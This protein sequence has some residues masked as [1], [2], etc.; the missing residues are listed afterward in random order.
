[1][2]SM[3]IIETSRSG[4]YALIQ[5]KNGKYAITLN[6]HIIERHGE[7]P[8]LDEALLRWGCYKYA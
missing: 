1:M 8:R 3:Q 5:L 4:E 2:Q 7:Y 6:G